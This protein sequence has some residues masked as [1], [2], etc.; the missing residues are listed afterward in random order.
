MAIESY[1]ITPNQSFLYLVFLIHFK[2]NQFLLPVSIFQPDWIRNRTFSSA[3]TIP[4]KFLSPLYNQLRG[5]GSK[6]ESYRPTVTF[7][8]FGK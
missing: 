8:V 4:W 3:A 2:T 5:K 6:S 1:K 7:L